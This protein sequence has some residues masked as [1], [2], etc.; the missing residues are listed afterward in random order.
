[1]TKALLP[2]PTSSADAILPPDI[3]LEVFDH[4][5][6]S[7]S[8][9]AL[10]D[11]RLV[12]KAL[13]LLVTP[14]LMAQREV[15]LRSFQDFTH[16]LVEAINPL[17]LSTQ[18][19]AP[20]GQP[21]EQQFFSPTRSGSTY[22]Q[23]YDLRHVRK[24]SADRISSEASSSKGESRATDIPVQKRRYDDRLSSSLLPRLDTLILPSATL[25][26]YSLNSMALATSTSDLDVK[27][28]AKMW[29]LPDHNEK[30]LSD[31]SGKITKLVVRYPTVIQDDI[32]ADLGSSPLSTYLRSLVNKLPLLED[33]RYENV[34]LQPIALR[35][36]SF[37]S[38]KQI[39]RRQRITAVFSRHARTPDMGGVI[40][41]LRKQQIV[42]S[43]AV[44]VQTICKVVEERIFASSEPGS[45]R[46]DLDG[47]QS[48][49][50][51][52]P[53]TRYEF[54]DAIQSIPQWDTTSLKEREK[55]QREMKNL[56][57]QSLEKQLKPLTDN[58]P[59]ARLAQEYVKSHI[60]LI[61]T[62]I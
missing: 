62:D 14:S 33:V 24:L 61:E 7:G 10:A 23:M 50:G 47:D 57:K 52:N 25:R 3:L 29:S 13:Y 17:S 15:S 35:L 2:Q 30:L 5:S 36:P 59:I 18:A 19:L 37:T 56:I 20:I 26:A 9:K 38:S 12:S 16:G 45:S 11:M 21:D 58:N 46:S 1:M 55:D 8:I 53:D 28:N 44:L 42:S 34:H 49:L 41:H 48:A 6:T 43:L 39:S 51:L 22:R 31:L 54:V 27:L 60:H 32:D 40:R 4:L